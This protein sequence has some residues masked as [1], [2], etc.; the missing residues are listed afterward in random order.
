MH[1][2]RLA[3]SAESVLSIESL[4]KLL[5]LALACEIDIARASTVN[6]RGEQPVWRYLNDKSKSSAKPGPASDVAAML[7]KY[8]ESAKKKLEKEQRRSQ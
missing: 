1:G 4:E 6:A 7:A 2:V 3:A 8:I 5:Q